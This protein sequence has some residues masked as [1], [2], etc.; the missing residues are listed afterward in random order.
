MGPGSAGLADRTQRL[1]VVLQRSLG[2]EA[3]ALYLGSQGGWHVRHEPGDEAQEEQDHVLGR[4]GTNE[5]MTAL[6]ILIYEALT[7]CKAITTPVLQVKKSKHKQLVICPKTP[8][9][10]SNPLT[11]GDSIRGRA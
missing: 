3:L 1:P 8:T 6:A 9:Y 7:K 4:R 2:Q 10:N 5:R 11:L